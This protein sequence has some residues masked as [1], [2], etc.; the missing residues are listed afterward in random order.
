VPPN[1]AS[2]AVGHIKRAVCTGI[3][4]PLAAGLAVERELQ[5][6]LFESADAAEGIAAY[7]NKTVPRFK[8]I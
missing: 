8:G 2:K 1:K 4:M 3:D 7:V 6:R 5:Q